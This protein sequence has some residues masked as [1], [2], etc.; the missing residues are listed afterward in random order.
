MAVTSAQVAVSTT[1][2]LLSASE[3]DSVSG[4]SVT[5]SNYGAISVHLGPDT[6]GAT[7]F[8]LPAGA[9]AGPI[10]LSPG[11]SLYAY[12]ASATTVDVLRTGV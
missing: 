9:S 7:G 4:Q 5:V 11:E 12:A 1:P 8:T 6:V 3:T 10:P 2:V